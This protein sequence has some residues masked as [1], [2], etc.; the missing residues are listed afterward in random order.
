[1]NWT[2]VGLI[3]GRELRDQLR[4]RRTLF[5]VVVLPLLLYPMMGISLLQ[6]TQFF[7]EHPTRVW[8]VGQQNLLA[9][10]SFL[11]GSEIASA[12]LNP[13]QRGLLSIC[14]SDQSDA[15]FQRL[16][17]EFKRDS[18]GAESQTL[19][20]AYIQ[21]ELRRHGSDLAVL[22]PK[23]VTATGD[24]RGRVSE[25]IPGI[26]LFLNTSSDRSRVAAERFLQVAERWKLA[27]RNESLRQAGL[28]PRLVEPFALRSADI[29]DQHGKRV[30]AWSR[31]LPLL[32]M[33]WSLTGAFYPA[34]DLCAGEK[35]RGTFETLLSSPASRGEIAI[36]K[37]L[38]VMIFS[39]ATC[40]LNLLSVGIT[41]FF[42][43][44]GSAGAGVLSPLGGMELPP[45]QSLLW[46]IL[47]MAPTA[48]LFSAL[49]LAAAAFARSSKEGQYYLVPL[50]M[51]CLPLMAIPLFP[52]TR[53][54]LGTSLLPVTGLILLLRALIEGDYVNAG[55]FFAPVCLVTFAGCW[56]AIRWVVT[57]FNSET[58]LFRASERFSLRRWVAGTFLQRQDLPTV[59]QALLCAVTILLVKFFAGFAVGLPSTFSGFAGQT[60]IVLL[61]TVLMPA[62][63][64][65][66]M[67]TR[68]PDWSLKLRLCRPSLVAA[69]MLMAICLS[70]LNTWLS[71]AVMNVYPMN[72]SVQQLQEVL[73]RIL[74]SA[75]S[76]PAIMLILA[77]VPAI[78]EELAFRGFILSG[79]QRMKSPIAAIALSSFFFALAH[80]VFQQSVLAFVSGCILGVVAWRTG[81]ILPALAYHAVHNSMSILLGEVS[82]GGWGVFRWLVYETEQG[83]VAY[84]LLPGLLLL[85]VGVGLLGWLF[86]VTQ[87]RQHTEAKENAEMEPVP[88]LA[89]S[90]L[91]GG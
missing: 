55:Q 87:P 24:G 31:I 46:L 22:I 42:V 50:I 10:P 44:S 2:N 64:M 48:A 32:I 80:A 81:S 39:F 26:Y 45:T 47:A 36:G 83:V 89:A 5:T 51:I 18:A 14:L 43:V 78:F 75:P 91:R 71:A 23:P 9:E 4:D 54:E 15:E 7:R 79:F 29:S 53:L 21:Q 11:E 20:N 34:V 40:L 56:L 3:L 82:Y 12:W 76:L 65:A 67:L 41:S 86:R 68:R 66:M 58:V 84:R 35:E 27:V 6:I 30:A 74:A 37:L 13:E 59:G 70:P 60:V 62:V 90:G 8:I 73:G 49:S 28:S 77:V 85:M 52:A 57:Q 72:Q 63:L 38:T 17:G 25:G 16:V 1:M 33:V 19:V 61:A 88:S 69:A